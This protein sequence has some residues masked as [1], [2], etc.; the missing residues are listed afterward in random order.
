MRLDEQIAKDRGGS[1][2]WQTLAML[3]VATAAAELALSGI[4]SAAK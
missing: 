1:E 4:F 2:I 3:V